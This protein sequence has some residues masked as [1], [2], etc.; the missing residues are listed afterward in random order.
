MKAGGRGVRRRFIVGG[1]V[2]AGVAL[3]VASVSSACTVA[4][5]FTWYSDGTF[6]KQGPTNSL[7]TAYATQAK[8]NTAHMLV[9]ANAEGEPGHEGHA[10]MFNFVNIN[11]NVR[12]SSASGFIGLTSGRITPTAGTWQICF[13]E[14]PTGNS[15]TIPVSFTVT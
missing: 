8:P 14:H 2:S 10:C 13:R 1:M 6:Q 9:T 12:M 4:V 11:P 15:A 3:A 5:G 7:I